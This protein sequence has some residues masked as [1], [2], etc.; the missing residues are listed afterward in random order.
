MYGYKL[1]FV[2][3]SPPYFLPHCIVEGIRYSCTWTVVA[4]HFS[5]TTGPAPC[6]VW[7]QTLPFD[8]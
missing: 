1:Q 6:V 7:H 4:V 8:N 5:Y 2:L 3:I